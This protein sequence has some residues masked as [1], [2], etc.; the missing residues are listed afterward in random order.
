MSM[1]KLMR[2]YCNQL[3]NAWHEP[4]RFAADR[5]VMPRL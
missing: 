5:G 4:K 3:N 2:H 1:E